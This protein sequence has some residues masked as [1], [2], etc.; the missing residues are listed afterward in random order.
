VLAAELVTDYVPD[1][2]GAWWQL[3]PSTSGI[4]SMSVDPGGVIFALAV[5]IVV[6][7]WRRGRWPRRR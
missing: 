2:S 4:N 5:V 1:E 3:R 6:E 7:W